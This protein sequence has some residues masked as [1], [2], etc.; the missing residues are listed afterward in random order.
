M[1]CDGRYGIRVIFGRCGSKPSPLSLSTGAGKVKPAVVGRIPSDRILGRS[2]S[3]LLRRRA[4]ARA[5]PIVH[6]GFV[7]PRRSARHTP[8]APCQE[9]LVNVQRPR[10]RRPD[11]K[12]H[13]LK[14]LIFL[15]RYSRRHDSLCQAARVSRYEKMPA[16]LHIFLMSLVGCRV[17]RYCDTPLVNLPP[18]EISFLHLYSLKLPPWRQVRR[19]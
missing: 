3:G 15:S 9:L 5:G 7:A 10:L 13:A 16:K 6:A 14:V 8:G 4:R 12:Y 18:L 11:N 2:E 19:T 17:T 1:T